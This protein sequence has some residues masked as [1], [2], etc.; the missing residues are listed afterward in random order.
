M[1]K[2]T[3]KIRV[4]TGTKIILRLGAILVSRLEAIN[5]F[6]LVIVVEK[7]KT[8]S[9]FTLTSLNHNRLN[10]VLSI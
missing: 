2:H 5:Y 6:T 10:L 3:F 7:L 4:K 9:G 1:R 8:D